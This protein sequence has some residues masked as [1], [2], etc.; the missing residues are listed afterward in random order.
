MKNISNKFLLAGDTFLSEIHLR[1]PGFAYSACE[2]FRKNQTG[3]QKLKKS[4]DSGDTY[5]NEPNKA[6]F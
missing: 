2:L 5:R 3:I 4:G 6:C 1:Q